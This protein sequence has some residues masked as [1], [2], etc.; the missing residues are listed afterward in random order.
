MSQ[1]PFSVYWKLR[2]VEIL[3]YA[4][5]LLIVFVISFLPL[6]TS[7]WYKTLV[8]VIVGLALTFS[9]CALLRA[10]HSSQN[11]FEGVVLVTFPF[12]WPADSQTEGQLRPPRRQ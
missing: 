11:G 9:L 3:I 6:S 8:Q 5:V 7:G 10:A 2:I 4:I 12:F 1:L